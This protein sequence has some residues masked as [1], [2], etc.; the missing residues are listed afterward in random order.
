MDVSA[1][2]GGLLGVRFERGG[3]GA[4]AV[5]CFGGDGEFATLYDHQR[6]AV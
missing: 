5:W 3:V 2:D 4:F 6:K 1:E